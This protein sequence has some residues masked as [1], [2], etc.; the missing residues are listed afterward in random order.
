MLQQK[1][2]LTAPVTISQR[3]PYVGHSDKMQQLVCTSLMQENLTLAIPSKSGI[4]T[5]MRLWKAQH[6]A[7]R[8]TAWKTARSRAGDGAEVWWGFRS[9]CSGMSYSPSSCKV[10]VRQFFLSWASPFKR[11]YHAPKKEASCTLTAAPTYSHNITMLEKRNW[12]FSL[13]SP[14]LP[15]STIS[16][17]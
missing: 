7:Q 10:T 6:Y 14:S 13:P 4:L 16:M 3:T 2:L 15:P 12:L 9:S 11:C 8:E 17:H 5:S 1:L